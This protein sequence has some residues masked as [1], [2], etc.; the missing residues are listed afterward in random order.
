M[1]LERFCSLNWEKTASL[2]RLMSQPI[3][4]INVVFVRFLDDSKIRGN[5]LVVKSFPK[6]T[7]VKI[8]SVF[9]FSTWKQK[10]CLGGPMWGDTRDTHQRLAPWEVLPLLYKK[11]VLTLSRHTI[12]FTDGGGVK[13]YWRWRKFWT[14]QNLLTIKWGSELRM[15]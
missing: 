4:L 5:L 3:S 12:F 10:V 14:I 15:L 1:K 13:K 9:G 11:N 6:E 7:M 8:H 2:S